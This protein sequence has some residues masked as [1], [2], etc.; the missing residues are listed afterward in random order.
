MSTEPWQW[1]EPTWRGHVE[2]RPRRAPR[3]RPPLARRRA[4]RRGA[5]VR[6][7][8]RDDPA[9][10]RRDRPGQA[11]AG[12]VRL[13]RR[14]AADPGAAGGT[15]SRRRSS[16]RRCRRCCTPRR[17]A[18]Y[19]AAGH[20]VAHARLDP[21]A[22]HA[23]G[24]RRRARADLPRPR[25]PRRAHRRAA[26]SASARRRGTSPTPPCGVIR[27]L[28]LALRLVADGRRR[29]ATRSLADGEPT[30]LVELPV[31]WIRDDA[32][33]FTMD[34]YSALRPY[35]PPREVLRHVARRV[36]RGV[37]RGRPVPAHH[38][39]ARHRPPLPHGRPAASCSTTS[40]RATASG[41]PRT[42]RSP[43]TY[44]PRSRPF[45]RDSS[46]V[47]GAGDVRSFELR[48]RVRRSS[49]SQG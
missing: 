27:E 32:P 16:C 3:S 4:G 10:R 6:L 31:E 14:R 47:R 20:E 25:H 15:A 46:Y 8:P 45:H 37:R 44:G 33:Y 41:S 9:A 23:A 11:L 21:R 26:R 12:R 35:T 2:A 7:R 1:D 48:D 22:Q 43:S 28:G 5:V 13:A 19:V 38:A 39:P 18:R 36:R 34:R 29:A 24:R 49:G 42:P 40:R 30:G 17:R